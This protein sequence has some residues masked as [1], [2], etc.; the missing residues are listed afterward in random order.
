MRHSKLKACF[1]L[2]KEQLWNKDMFNN[3][4]LNYQLVIK[5]G[6]NLVIW[7][8]SLAGKD[9]KTNQTSYFNFRY[10]SITFRKSLM[11]ALLSDNLRGNSTQQYCPVQ[12]PCKWPEKKDFLKIINQY[13]HLS[14][15]IFGN[16]ILQLQNY[17]ISI[18]HVLILSSVQNQFSGVMLK[19][20]I[21]CG[22]S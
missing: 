11:F 18:E 5:L 1:V 7:N 12:F 15:Y 14:Y 17:I 22:K 3:T 20:G 9:P 6:Y 2:S 8:F 10:M 13:L 16:Q 19:F 4:K 21:A